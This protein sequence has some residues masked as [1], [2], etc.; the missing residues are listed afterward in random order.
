MLRKI[1]LHSLVLS[2]ST[3]RLQE[4]EFLDRFDPDEINKPILSEYSRLPAEHP[5]TESNGNC[6]VL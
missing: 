6:S 4:E 3:S 5:K 1:P 2:I